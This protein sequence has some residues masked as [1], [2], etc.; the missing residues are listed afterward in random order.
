MSIPFGVCGFARDF[1]KNRKPADCLCVKEKERERERAREGAS[2]FFLSAPV[3][4]SA[5]WEAAP[6]RRTTSLCCFDVSVS[7]RELD[8]VLVSKAPAAEV[9]C[10]RAVAFLFSLAMMRLPSP[11]HRPEVR[12][13]RSS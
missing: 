11:F 9:V 10:V 2:L 7:L 4:L 3:W 13:H 8:V 12:L 1:V 6:Q 5:T